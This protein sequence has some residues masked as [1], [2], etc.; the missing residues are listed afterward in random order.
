MDVGV[1][2]LAGEGKAL[3]EFT[4]TDVAVVP[5]ANVDVFGNGSHVGNDGFVFG[6]VTNLLLEE[7]QRDG[8]SKIHPTRCGLLAA[9]EH[10]QQGRLPGT[11]GT[12][13]A[14]ATTRLRSPRN[15]AKQP[16]SVAFSLQLNTQ[17]VGIDDPATQKA[18]PQLDLDITLLGGRGLC[19][20]LGNPVDPAL[21]L[22]AP[23]LSTLGQPCQFPTQLVTLMGGR[24][25]LDVDERRLALQVLLIAPFKRQDAMLIQFYDACADGIEEV[26]VVRYQQQS[27]RRVGELVLQPL[28][29]VGVEMVG[30]LVE[31]QQIGLRHQRSGDR[32]ALSLTTR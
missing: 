18:M 25:F 32:Y 4:S 1:L 28:H 23:R 17:I 9:A 11:V 24:G 22:G 30:G 26:P 8:F 10:A 29:R 31:D 2:L 15:V 20:H 13:H 5:Q 14:N 27:A 16:A 12:N 6:Q 19:L 3:A 21:L 7:T